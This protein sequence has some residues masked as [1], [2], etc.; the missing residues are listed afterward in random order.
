MTGRLQIHKW[1]SMKSFIIKYWLRILVTV[2][3]A[4]FSLLVAFLIWFQIQLKANQAIEMQRLLE[5]NEGVLISRSPL[6]SS[7]SVSPKINQQVSEFK[8]AITDQYS[9][10]RIFSNSNE[11]EIVMIRLYWK[12]PVLNTANQIL[13]NQ[14]RFNTLLIEEAKLRQQ[15]KP[16]F[17]RL[18]HRL[19]TQSSDTFK[20]E[21]YRLTLSRAQS[22]WQERTAFIEQS[23]N[24]NNTDSRSSQYIQIK[25]QI[26]DIQTQL[27]KIPFEETDRRVIL[28]KKLK[29]LK[30]ELSHLSFQLSDGAK[31]I[32]LFPLLRFN[33][34]E[35]DLF[36]VAASTQQV[37]QQIKFIEKLLPSLDESLI[38]L[39]KQDIK[40][41]SP[42]NQPEIEIRR[43]PITYK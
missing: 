24:W 11:S 8:L 17:Q 7:I 37:E 19:T 20:D 32:Q 10:M 9:P 12:V 14:E 4:A 36:A 38:L 6:D 15:M 16:V 3:L 40:N 41:N 43:R 13:D 27:M 2:G 31:A 30:N 23:D 22:L 28:G 1:N 34:D 25:D 39:A 29:L 18:I 21:A 5:S 26:K 35:K 33:I 42:T